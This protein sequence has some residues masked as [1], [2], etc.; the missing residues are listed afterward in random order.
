VWKKNI[1]GQGTKARNPP[2]KGKIEEKKGGKKEC[3]KK[4]RE[5]KELENGQKDP[6]FKNSQRLKKS[7]RE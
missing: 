1:K 5:K 2:P 7:P 3:A 4:K 6:F